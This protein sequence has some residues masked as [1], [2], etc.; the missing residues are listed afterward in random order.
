MERST[1]V[2]QNRICGEGTLD[3]TNHNGACQR[4]Q[5]PVRIVG[6]SWKLAD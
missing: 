3:P 4:S 1:A 5:V 6:G 2:L